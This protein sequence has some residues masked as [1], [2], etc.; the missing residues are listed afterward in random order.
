MYFEQ[1]YLGCLAHASY[2]LISG[3]EAVVVDPQRDVDIYIEA[4]KQQGARIR[5]VFETHLHADFVSGHKELALRTGAQIYIGPNGGATL[6]HV[7]VRE[8]FELRVGTFRIQVL[9]TPGHTPES[10]CLLIIDE[11]KS[12]QPWAVLTG[13]TL[14]VGDVGRPDLSKAFSATVLA[15]ILFD[16]LHNK[17][18]TLPDDVT[19]YPGHGAGSLCGRNLGTSRSSTIGTERLTNYA[20]QV[21]ERGV[22]IRELTRNLPPCPDY[23]PHDA[24]INRAGAPALQ[25]LPKLTA[26]KGQELD[27]ILGE[28]GVAIDVRT[29]EEFAA[30][31]VPG[32][33]NIPLSGQF[34]S[35]AGTLVDLNSRPVLIADNTEE[36]D[37]A[38]T[39]LAR[40][41]L[42]LE[43]GYLEGGVN[44]WKNA[45][46][47]L[48]FFDQIRV[49][50]LNT[51]L[52]S[53][54]VRV[55]DVRRS[56]EWQAGHI[57]V[58]MHHP[59][60]R[61]KA[62]LPDLNRNETVFVM[63]K[64]GYRSSIACSVLQRAG[65]TDVTNVVGGFDA[66]KGAGL[67]IVSETMCAA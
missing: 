57:A 55:L 4:A 34:A 20:L 33:I 12:P 45:G 3:E 67:P 2:L 13:D 14:F 37:E 7:E 52:E 59:L 58:A 44:E 36:L 49:Q 62:K 6:P 28:G 41:G 31:H 39:R 46:Y 17:L 18:L 24:Q 66:W 30:G 64:G 47:E 26:V 9:E 21:K 23:F 25:D 56:G 51:R 29:A 19:V 27:R 10:I 48:E 54:G 40:I 32:S 8:G 38:R 50:D 16:S 35:W 11:E 22:F 61:F 53:E 60:D 65:F 15:G 43:R 42:D 5:H 63:C 1:F